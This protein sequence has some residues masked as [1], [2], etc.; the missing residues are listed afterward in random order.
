M[1]K[2]RIYITGVGGQGTLIATALIGQAA[3]LAG[4]NANLSEI[5]GMAQRGGIVESSVTLGNLKDPMVSKGEA[6]ILLGF[7]PAETI[8]AA[9]RCNPG[10]VV[11]TNTTPVQPFTVSTGRE[12][13]PDLTPALGKLGQRVGKLVQLNADGLARKAGN[14]LA[15]NIVML[16]ALA[17]HGDLPMTQEQFRESIRKNTKSKFLDMNLKAFELG[18]AA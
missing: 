17:R 4:I 14:I 12:E 10:S 9:S 18:Y 1:S 13:Y 3:L 16:G 7:E 15:L 5:H 2:K 11:I 8:R 6:D